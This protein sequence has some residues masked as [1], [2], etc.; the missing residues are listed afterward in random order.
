MNQ[1]LIAATEYFDYVADMFPVMCASDEFVSFPRA[2]KAS[3]LYNKMESL[4]QDEI[5][6]AVTSIKGFLGRFE[7]M[8]PV[9][10]ASNEKEA[11]HTVRL[12]N[13]DRTTDLE[14]L[15][16]SAKTLLIELEQE[17]SFERDPLL[18][19]K[20]GFI[21]LDHA[22]NKPADSRAER[23][24]RI[25]QRL[26]RLPLVIKSGKNNA[27]ALDSH[28]QAAI[29]LIPGC[30]GYLKQC[31]DKFPKQAQ[32][33]GDA[34]FAYMDHLKNGQPSSTGS[35]DSRALLE[36][37]LQG[38]FKTGV[39]LE[40][41]FEILQ[42]D[43]SSTRQELEGMAAGI[44]SGQNWQA[45]YHEYSP[46]QIADMDVLGLYRAAWEEI[47]G[48][49]NN[50]FDIETDPLEFAQTPSYLMSVRSSASFAASL[51]PSEVSYF[52]ITDKFESDGLDPDLARRLAREYKFLAAHETVPGHHLLDSFRRNLK[53]PVRRQVESPIF[54][55]GWACFAESLLI[56]TGW[57]T[58]PTEKLVDAKRRLWRTARGLADAGVAT[59]ILSLEAA[60]EL[61]VTCGFSYDEAM[62]QAVRFRLNPGYQLCYSFGRLEF[63]S[64]WEEYSKTTDIFAFCNSVLMQGEIPF[65]ALRAY[66]KV[67]S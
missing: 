1:H 14:V 63:E 33:A 39:S 38:P 34:L 5:Q 13:L 54:Y 37:K 32:Q 23:D 31:S 43:L 18:C 10:I 15:I 4:D 45:I 66:L 7:S 2:E 42:A 25:Y 28:R 20:V 36:L 53:N 11:E 52:Y 67:V 60:A 55:E 40:E 56:K 62:R 61:L 44:N 8:L 48:F 22:I 21:G 57:I 35:F 50:R 46:L 3:M 12:S 24:E 49:F 27:P 59:G 19:L 47:E 58:D 65:S 30:L 6:E 64:I 17:K 29:G 26:T 16:S 9:N 41:M 51:K